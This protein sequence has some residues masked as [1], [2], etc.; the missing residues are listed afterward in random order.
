[1]TPK[2]KKPKKPKLVMQK[3][4]LV[5]GPVHTTASL[6]DMKKAWPCATQTKTT[7]RDLPAEIPYM[8]AF[9]ENAKV[10]GAS[11]RLV[12]GSI[13]AKVKLQ[14]LDYYLELPH[15]EEFGCILSRHG[16]YDPGLVYALEKLIPADKLAALKVDIANKVTE[17]ALRDRDKILQAAMNFKRRNALRALRLAKDSIQKFVVSGDV[18]KEDFDGIW[19]AI[20][21]ESVHDS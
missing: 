14:Y 10:I 2:L 8:V 12:G 20:I 9:W 7:G 3:Y 11:V 17:V 5:S 19:N 4:V 1:M 13:E 15:G 18:T 21:V 6:A 16:H